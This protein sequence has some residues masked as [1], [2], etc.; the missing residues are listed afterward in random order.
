MARSSL[1]TGGATRS[2]VRPRRNAPPDDRSPNNATSGTPVDATSPRLENDMLA[3]AGSG[4]IITTTD[5]REAVNSSLQ[6]R[7]SVMTQQSL[8][9]TPRD[10]AMGFLLLTPQKSSGRERSDPPRGF[11]GAGGWGVGGGS[12]SD[13]GRPR[14]R[15]PTAVLKVR[16]WVGW[17]FGHGRGRGRGRI[18]TTETSRSRR[19][20]Q[21]RRP[22]FQ[23]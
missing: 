18:S 22:S 9:R 1:V 15:R 12:L 2:I 3:M 7:T 16:R 11:L 17:R 8:K 6:T 13:L 5:P 23:R 19:G 14:C 21:P 20:P 4:W 10:P